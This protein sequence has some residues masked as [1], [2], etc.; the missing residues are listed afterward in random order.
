LL[1]FHSFV[2]VVRGQAGRFTG[3]KK[4]EAVVPGPG[5]AEGGFNGARDPGFRNGGRAGIWLAAC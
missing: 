1:W 4:A 2:V 3:G 5:A